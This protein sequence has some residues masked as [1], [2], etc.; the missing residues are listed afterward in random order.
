MATLNLV[1]IAP[2]LEGGSKAGHVYWFH[3]SLQMAFGNLKEV[4]H[5]T[6][7]TKSSPEDWFVGVFSNSPSARLRLSHF[8][9]L[10]LARD[11]GACSSQILHAYGIG[12]QV[13]IHV[14]DGGFREYLL[15]SALLDMNP[16]YSCSF[17]FSNVIDPWS[18]LFARLLL[19]K[20]PLSR[21]GRN[22]TI[23]SRMLPYTEVRGLADLYDQAIKGATP[24]LYPMFSIIDSG[25]HQ[26]Q[27]GAANERKID[28]IFFPENSYE[29]DLCAKVIE[30]LRSA[31]TGPKT[32]SIQP[33]WGFTLPE[34]LLESSIIGGIEIVPNSVTE[35]EYRDM[36]LNS[37][38]VVL[39]Y[40]NTYHYTYQG[41]G[42]LLD[43]LASGCHVVVPLET[44]LGQYSVSTRSVWPVDVLEVSNI[45][46]AIE[47]AWGSTQISGVTVPTAGHLASSLLEDA[48]YLQLSA[49]GTTQDLKLHNQLSKRMR[50]AYLLLDW[51]QPLVGLAKLVID[52]GW[53]RRWVHSLRRGES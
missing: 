2:L 1:T 44:S 5:L 42:R 3:Q 22:H 37:R 45:A 51:Y 36:Y 50:F 13:H 11:V 53:V 9:F 24:K 23:H 31:E 18:R 14:Y 43:A 35:L 33:R 20:S 38:V 19:S 28:V 16:R 47:K 39:P 12:A 40:T 6:F 48:Q 25:A 52:I 34:S 21:S 7:G 30:L 49:A 15:V 4:S 17:N 10:G 29:L 26:Q 32:F 41:S 8:P 46:A 27:A